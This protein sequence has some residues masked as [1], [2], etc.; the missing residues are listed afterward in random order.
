MEYVSRLRVVK[1]LLRP[2]VGQRVLDA[3]CGDGR[4]CFEIKDE[5]VDVTGIDYSERALAFAKAFSPEVEFSVQ[6]L[7]D[8]KLEGQFDT[9]V[10]IE[11]L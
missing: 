2:F 5:D 3:G 1:D 11:T 6:D 4:F 10:L 8:I 7:K 9:I